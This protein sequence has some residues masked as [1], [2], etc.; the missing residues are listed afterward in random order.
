MRR[1]EFMLG[2]VDVKCLKACQAMENRVRFCHP[3]TSW[4]DIASA[5]VDGGYG[6]LPVVDSEKNLLGIVSEYDLL[7][8]LMDEQ[9]ENKV[10]AEDIMT[11][12]TVTVE[13]D[14]PITDVIR[15]L[16]ENRLIR[17]PVVA[18]KDKLVGILARRDVLLCYLQASSEPQHLI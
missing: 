1:S 10:K 12:D 9:D 2:G 17:V 13:E 7:K 4:R 14:T 8:V 16:E 18:K 3:S 15:V 11:K 5:L 6:S